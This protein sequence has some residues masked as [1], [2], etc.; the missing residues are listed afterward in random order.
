MLLN[1]GLGI[2][3][4]L[5]MRQELG[6]LDGKHGGL[7]D[8]RLDGN[9]DCADFRHTVLWRVVG[10]F[11]EYTFALVRLGPELFKQSLAGPSASRP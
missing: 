10:V 2:Q 11:L 6:C 9:R 8:V 1:G 7:H 3:L 4:Q 5:L